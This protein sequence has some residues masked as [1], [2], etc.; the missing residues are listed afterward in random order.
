M[1]DLQLEREKIKLKE[2]QFRRNTVKM[3]NEFKEDMQKKV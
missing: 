1:D 3:Q 2:E